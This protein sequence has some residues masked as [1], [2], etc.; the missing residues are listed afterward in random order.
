MH[1]HPVW[2]GFMLGFGGDLMLWKKFGIGGEPGVGA[3]LGGVR[4]LPDLELDGATRHRREREEEFMKL[5]N[6]LSWPQRSVLLLYFIEEFSLQEIAGITGSSVGTVK[7][8]LH[9]ALRA[10]RL[11]L[12]EMGVVS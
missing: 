9:Y 2:H 6:Q 7:S 8:R 3:G 5:L 4:P 10:L 1:F 12:E 11:I